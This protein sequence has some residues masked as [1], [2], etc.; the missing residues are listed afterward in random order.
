[1]I[2]FFKLLVVKTVNQNSDHPLNKSNIRSLRNI[3]WLK[4]LDIEN[5]MVY[6][7]HVVIIE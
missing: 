6:N 2:F 3:I 4:R 1:M 7:K 5:V